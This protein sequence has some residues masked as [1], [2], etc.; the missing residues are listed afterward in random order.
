MPLLVRRDRNHPSVV[1]WSICNEKLCDSSSSTNDALRLKAL[2]HSL[3]PLGG[4]PVSANSRDNQPFPVGTSSPLD[5][6]GIDYTT[7]QYNAYHAR[8]PTH[9]MISSES[10]SAYSDRDE[11]GDDSSHVDGYDKKWVGR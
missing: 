7:E 4:R 10:S 3:D 6:Q 5:L 9:P 8:A 1:I 11:Y 2:F